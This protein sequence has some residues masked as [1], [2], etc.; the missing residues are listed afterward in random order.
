MLLLAIPPIWPYGYYMFL[1]L[2]VCGAAVFIAYKAYE[3]RK[4]V[5]AYTAGL[6]ALLFNPVIPVHLNKEMW[7]I[8]DLITAIIVFVSIW[9]L[10]EI[11]NN[12]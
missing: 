7:A 3:Q 6:L 5:L 10:K 8:I 1:R 9:F 11:N 12:K 2:V 4:Q